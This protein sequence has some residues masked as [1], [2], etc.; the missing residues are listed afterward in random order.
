[1]PPPLYA[2]DLSVSPPLAL[3]QRGILPFDALPADAIRSGR[4]FLAVAA[5]A[6]STVT[7]PL[8]APFPSP[9]KAARVWP[10]LL[11]AALPFPVE[12]ASAHYSPSRLDGR[13]TRCTA[14]AIRTS[15][16]RDFLASP[17]LDALPPA[18]AF[19]EPLALWSLHASLVPP[20]DDAPSALVYL[21]GDHLTILLARG[22]R[23]LAAHT[24]RTPPSALDPSSWSLRLRRIL[25]AFADDAQSAPPGQ[26]APSDLPL[27]VWWTGPAAA[28]DVLPPLQAAFPPGS[29]HARH[30]DPSIF[31]P[32]ALLRLAAAPATAPDLLVGPLVPPQRLRRAARRT[33]L[34]SLL[35]L[36]LSLLVIGLSLLVRANHTARLYTLKNAIAQTSLVKAPSGL[37]TLLSDRADAE[38]APFWDA[39]ETLRT[40][41][42]LAPRVLSAVNA[43]HDAS[44]TVTRLSATPDSLTATL[45]APGPSR[46]QD[47]PGWTVTL[48]PAPDGTLTLKG[49]P[50]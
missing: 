35:L 30:D 37:E 47:L 21:G 24:L 5:P 1:M 36:F 23:L 2:L 41:P 8:V 48:V 12:A 20:K 3:S 7:R 38:A 14:A 6:V 22:P 46:L 15:D 34:L 50:R 33:T 32:R 10:A 26:V 16:L 29:R 45:A 39:V 49:T 25:A 11:D 9:R 4:A 42:S 40:P 19:A 28:P 31:L 17:P 43:L 13:Q 44:A 27:S 18:Y